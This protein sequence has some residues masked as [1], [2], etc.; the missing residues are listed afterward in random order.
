ME[1][2]EE[3]MQIVETYDLTGSLRASAALAGIPHHTVDR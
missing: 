3:A 2:E 1:S